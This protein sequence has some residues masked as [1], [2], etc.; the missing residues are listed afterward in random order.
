MNGFLAIWP[1]SLGN[2]RLRMTSSPMTVF[3]FNWDRS[4]KKPGSWTSVSQY[5]NKHR[6]FKADIPNNGSQNRAYQNRS[7]LRMVL[8]NRSF[9]MLD[10]T[11]CR[12]NSKTRHSKN[13]SQNQAYHLKTVHTYELFSKPFIYCETGVLS[14]SQPSHDITISS[15]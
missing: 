5:Q 11:Y 14:T 7:F 8:Q 3:L 12:G 4:N 6:C 1:V 13:S 2:E 10:E 15:Y 9:N